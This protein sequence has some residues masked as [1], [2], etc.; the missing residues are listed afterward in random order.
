MYLFKNYTVKDWAG[1]AEVYSVPLRVGKY[2]LG[3]TKA[4]PEALIQA[5][6]PIGPDAAGIMTSG[7]KSAGKAADT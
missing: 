4:D 1:F 7:A 5:V 2:K 3:G 6:R